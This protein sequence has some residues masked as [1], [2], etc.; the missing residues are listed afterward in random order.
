LIMNVIDALNQHDDVA[1]MRSKTQ[2]HNPLNEASAVA[3]TAIKAINIAGLPILVV[4]FGLLVWVRR[5]A[6]KNSIRRM[7]ETE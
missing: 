4:L 3:K 2:S 1:L 6:R 5:H 7:F